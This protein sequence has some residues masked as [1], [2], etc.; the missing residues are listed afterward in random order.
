[1][2]S[3]DL[4]LE[5]CSVSLGGKA[6]IGE[7][8][9]QLYDEHYASCY[10]FL[11]FTGSSPDDALELLQEGFVRLYQTLRKGVQVD[12]PRSWLIRVLQRLSV[13]EFRR[14]SRMSSL[15]EFPEE[16]WARATVPDP[17]N[18]ETELLNRERVERLR[19]AVGALTA[20]QYQYLRL[21]A[22]GLKFRE[23]ADL[24]GVAVGSV[25]DA[26]SRAIRKLGKLTD[27]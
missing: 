8:V 19:K 21:R 15:D 5:G 1:M 9:Q 16:A 18:P 24:Y 23:I 27:V 7:Q 10:R 2:S 22:E 4:T 13:D 12:N 3:A 17:A 25:F 20:V 6:G 26:C 14:T 11:I